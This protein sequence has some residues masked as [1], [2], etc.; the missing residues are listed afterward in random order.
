MNNGFTCHWQVIVQCVV[1]N[2]SLSFP[3]MLIRD[4]QREEKWL[5]VDLTELIHDTKEQASPSGECRTLSL[6]S[7]SCFLNA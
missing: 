6:I 4:L 3:L 2:F 5:D 1:V 7:I